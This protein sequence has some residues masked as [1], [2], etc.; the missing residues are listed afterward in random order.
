MRFST[1]ISIVPEELEEK[2]IDIA[3]KAGAGGATILGAKG[4][5]LEQEKTF[6]N[7]SYE[8]SD[9]VLLF[10]LER[11]T[12]LK[13]IKALS[14]ELDME[15][16]SNGIVFSMPIEHLAGV[17]PKQLEFFENQIKSKDEE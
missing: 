9:S 17:S 7:L 15:G 2:A 5:G 8:R 16:S 11:K 6:L 10:I 12:A 1:V 4:I 3:K 13:V 14:V